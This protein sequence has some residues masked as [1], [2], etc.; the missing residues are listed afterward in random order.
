MNFIS[1]FRKFVLWFHL[2]LIGQGYR[3]AQTGVATADSP[4][5]PYTFIEAFN[6]NANSW[7]MNLTE[8]QK[9]KVFPVSQNLLIG[10]SF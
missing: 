5:G 8:E 2:E 1:L 10:T 3:A 9:N 6:P 4:T 7:P